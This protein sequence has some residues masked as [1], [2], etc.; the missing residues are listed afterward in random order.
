MTLKSRID[1]IEKALDVCVDTDISDSYKAGY[2]ESLLVAI[3]DELT[4]LENDPELKQRIN[5]IY[6]RC[7][8]KAD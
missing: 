1:L 2:C 6:G 5:S 7:I 3:H 4:A 8:E